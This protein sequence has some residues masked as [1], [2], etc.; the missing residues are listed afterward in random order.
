MNS[1]Y[2]PPV[3]R[4]V[5][6]VRRRRPAKGFV[7]ALLG[8]AL[9]SLVSAGGWLT[10]RLHP[11]FAVRRVVLDGVPETRRAE[12]EE[13][14]DPWIGQ[15]LL[16]ADLNGPVGAL[17]ARSWVATASAR[18]V[19]PDAIVV[20]VVARSPV[21]LARH[22]EHEGELWTV[23]QDGRWLGPYAGR[24]ATREDDFVLI[25]LAEGT[26][27]AEEA[28]RLARG[29][30]FLERL[31]SDDPDL[32]RRLSELTVLSDGFL[33]VDRGEHA[34][35]RFGLEA[36]EPGRAAGLWRAFLALR[37]EAERLGLSLAEADL[38]FSDRIVL[39]ASAE[40]GRGKT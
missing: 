31:R 2:R 30:A 16:F 33:A 32:L 37:P 21:A 38:R 27:P 9:A 36:L 8:A 29:T 25:A 34:S 26:A 24:A 6:P 23:D 17:S 15:P 20:H 10:L 28:P 4:A 1:F 18:R 12:A 40:G 7:L 11:R 5:R 19:V 13:L 39:K 35:L 14:M 3:P 22:P